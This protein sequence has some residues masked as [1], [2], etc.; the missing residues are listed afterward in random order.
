MRAACDMLCKGEF[1]LQHRWSVHLMLLT[2]SLCPR[3]RDTVE[4]SMGTLRSLEIQHDAA[5]A[6]AAERNRSFL[7]MQA[8]GRVCGSW[9]RQAARGGQRGGSETECGEN[10]INDA[11]AD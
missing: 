1:R 5:L 10:K 4:C 6:T 3:S 11:S 7:I 9:R 2:A 8:E